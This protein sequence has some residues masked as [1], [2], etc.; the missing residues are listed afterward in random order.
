M[1]HH[2]SFSA[3]LSAKMGGL[4]GGNMYQ[5]TTTEILHELNL[6]HAVL[7]EVQE[8]NRAAIRSS[9]RMFSI[10]TPSKTFAATQIGQETHLSSSEELRS[11]EKAPG[12]PPISSSSP[13]LLVRSKPSRHPFSGLLLPLLSESSLS[14]SNGYHADHG[15]GGP[16]GHKCRIEAGD[17][18]PVQTKGQGQQT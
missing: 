12:F 1:A 9:I 6:I 18:K 10:I 3:R 14:K 17:H 4:L 2:K 7:L 16:G 5:E 15:A 8:P 13:S 11:S